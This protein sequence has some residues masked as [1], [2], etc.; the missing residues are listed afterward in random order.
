MSS[1]SRLM[2]GEGEGS[3]APEGALLPELISGFWWWVGAAG[4]P[5]LL[6]RLEKTWCGIE[7]GGGKG[8]EHTKSP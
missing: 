4:A 5:T 1:T 3:T 2:R 6:A 8:I 7:S